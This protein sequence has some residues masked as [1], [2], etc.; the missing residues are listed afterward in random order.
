MRSVAA[1]SVVPVLALAAGCVGAVSTSQFG[2][3][4]DGGGAPPLVL[5]DAA[6]VATC[7]DAAKLVYVLSTDN[8][9]Y[10]FQPQNKQFTEIGGL[11]CPAGSM[12]PNSMA[13]D[14][15]AIAWINY[16]ASDSTGDTAGAIFELNTMTG[17]CQPTQIELPQG[18]YRIG[19]GFS[20]DVAGGDTETLFVV[21]AS[22]NGVADSPGLGKID[23]TNQTLITGGQFT[24]TLAGLGAELTGTGDGRLFAFFPT[25]PV[26]VAQV[27]KSSGATSAPIALPGVETPYSWAFSF[28]GGDLYLYTA[29][30]PT[31]QPSRT[32]DVTHYQPSNGMLDTAYM[33]DIG[34]TIIGAGVS[35]CAPAVPP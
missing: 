13:V 29:P 9:L 33:T 31:Q 22:G 23:F 26:Q 24:G 12:Q 28:W 14:R 32:T 2:A 4:D 21:G 25:T 18:W 20:S 30:D 17:D 19:M 35:T 8:N 6:V 10:S 27:D 11:S 16:V 1:A 7:S 15:N 34:F 5:N 3:D